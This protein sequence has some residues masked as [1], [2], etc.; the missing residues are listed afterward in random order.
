MD[1]VVFWSQGAGLGADD[2]NGCAVCMLSCPVWRTDH[3]QSLTF[4][5]RMR[6]LQ[7]RAEVEEVSDSVGACILC[8]SCEPVCSYEVKSVI[9]TL[10]MRASLGSDE[11][12]V[13]TVNPQEKATGRV[14]L[15]GP[16][17]ASNADMATKTLKALGDASMFSDSGIDISE[18]MEAGRHIEKERLE[19]F[20]SSLSGASE[21]ITTDGLIYRL[22]RQYAPDLRVTGLGEAMI[23][24]PCAREAMGP[25]DLYV[26]DARTYNSDFKRLVLVYDALRQEREP[27]MNLDLHRVATPTGAGPVGPISPHVDPI[28]QARWIL[29]GRPAKRIIVERLEDMAPMS[30]ASGLPVI[31][32]AELA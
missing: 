26:I 30:E 28:G 8:G 24:L 17:L 32:I 13:H 3:D 25:D 31:F 21:V 16:M 14:L 27:M 2:C 19:G 9:R 5:G 7:G 15:A 4:C 11:K 1:R 23:N 6:S 18:A 29:K 12:S 20:I 22:L 10:E